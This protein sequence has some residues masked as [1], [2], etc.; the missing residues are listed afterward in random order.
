MTVIRGIVHVF[1][2][3]SIVV[4]VFCGVIGIIEE[5]TGSPV[6]D[7]NGGVVSFYIN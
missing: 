6:T 2:I 7:S 4:M 3:I 5:M 1:N